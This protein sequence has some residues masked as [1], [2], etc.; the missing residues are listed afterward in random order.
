[1]AL[2]YNNYVTCSCEMFLFYIRIYQTLKTLLIMSQ[3]L[4]TSS[5]RQTLLLL[6]PLLHPLLPLLPLPL[7]HHQ[8]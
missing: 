3:S 2:Y 6:N 1:M 5:L 8:L 4:L 7:Y